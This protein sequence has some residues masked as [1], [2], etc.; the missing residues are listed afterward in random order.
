M[1]YVT[2]LFGVFL[3]AVGLL[4]QGSAYLAERTGR[5]CEVVGNRF[6]EPDVMP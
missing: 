4:L 5:I 2:V 3:V 1:N 6:A